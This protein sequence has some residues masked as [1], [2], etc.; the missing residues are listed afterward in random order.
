MYFFLILYFL[1]F[2]FFPRRA[3]TPREVAREVSLPTTSES[4]R[5]TCICVCRGDMYIYFFFFFPAEH[6]FRVKLPVK[7]LQGESLRA[8][9]TN[10]RHSTEIHSNADTKHEFEPRSLQPSGD[11]APQRKGEGYITGTIIFFFL[12]DRGQFFF[13]FFFTLD[14]IY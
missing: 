9:S 13:N 7:S 12:H 11:H 5:A 4:T 3:H 10:T 6:T 1:L 14:S 2:F 8:K